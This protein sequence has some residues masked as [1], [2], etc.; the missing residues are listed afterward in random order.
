MLKK[1]N[2]IIIIIII[3]IVILILNSSFLINNKIFPRI[4]I[5][6]ITAKSD[7]WNNEKRVWKKY[8][9]TYPNID[10]FFIECNNTEGMQTIVSN[11][12]ESYV[13][14]IYQKSLDSLKKV[15]DNYDFYI[16]G[17]LSTFYIFEYLTDYVKK[18]PQNI[19]IY[20]GDA[21]WHSPAQ[22]RIHNPPA[23]CHSYECDWQRNGVAGTA[24]L[25]NKRA[26]KLLLKYGFDKKYYNS[27]RP[28]DHVIRNVFKDLNIPS[29][30]NESGLLYLWDFNLSFDDNFKQFKK[31]K[32]LFI[33]LKHENIDNYNKI[34]NKLLN[35]FYK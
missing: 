4:A 10:C 22:G 32:Y 5:L 9:D 25:L 34:T 8:G 14:G 30:Y 19:P 35:Y 23:S 33:R 27:K 12:K 20:T 31:H 13:P 24:I 21:S 15:G 28:D 17:N 18:L 26:R 7:R 1:K 11:C 3:I 6:I 29:I 16:R 2:I